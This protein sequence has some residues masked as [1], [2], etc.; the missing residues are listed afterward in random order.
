[1]MEINLKEFEEINP[2]KNGFD[3][4]AINISSSGIFFPIEICSKD[5]IK[6]LI[7]ENI[8]LFNFADEGFTINPNGKSKSSKK[9]VLNKG[10]RLKRIIFDE[11]KIKPNHY[12]FEKLDINGK[13]YYKIEFIKAKEDFIKKLKKEFPKNPER[14]VEVFEK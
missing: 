6:I 14:N 2:R 10:S 11:Y 4:K 3:K 1:M 13:I 7:N 12:K 5:K 8:I 9:V